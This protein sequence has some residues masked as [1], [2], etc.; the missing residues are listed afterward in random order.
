MDFFSEQDKAR[1]S[2]G[3]LV[4]MFIGAVLLLV[5][6]IYL[7]AVSVYTGYGT[8]SFTLWDPMVLLI[9]GGGSLV[10]IVLGSLYRLA[11]LSAGGI[12]VAESVGGM[13][14]SPDT[15][16]PDERRVLN[17]VEEMA[18]AS[19]MAVPPVYML[20]EEGINAFA[21]GYRQED[22]VIGVTRGAVHGL[23]RDE[24]Q[25]VIAHE[26]SHIFHGDMRLNIRL[27]GVL[28]GILMISLTGSL[29][30]RALW[31]T[32]G[33]RRDRDNQAILLAIA[34]AGIGMYVLG[35]LGVLFGNLI[36][37]AVSRQREYLA[38]ASAVQYTRNPQGIGDALKRLAGFTS[39]LRHPG[40]REASHM[41]FG[42]VANF[43]GMMATHPPLAERIRRIDPSFNAAEEQAL[44]AADTGSAVAGAA[45][46]AGGSGA[47]SD[48]PARSAPAGVPAEQVVASVGRPGE[49]HLAFGRRVLDEVGDDLRAAS[50][51]P[52]SARAVTYALLLDGE[53]DSVRQQ[54]WD[55]LDARADA[56]VVAVTR[57]LAERVLGLPTHA[58][59]PLLELCL[60]ALTQMAASQRA[61]ALSVIDALITADGKVT[62]FEYT[63]RHLLHIHLDAE[64]QA[65]RRAAG[66]PKGKD[67]KVLLSVL[68][69]VGSDDDAAAGA[70]FVAAAA[71]LGISVRADELLPS[72]Q[73]TWKAMDQALL[74]LVGAGPEAKR[75]YLRGCVAAVAHDGIITPGE[76]DLVRAVAA[77]F[78]LPLP[79]IIADAA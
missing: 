72:Q 8:K 64:F 69:R 79:P 26:F 39:N 10:I 67:L 59:L 73:S 28:Y 68:S 29:L 3:R 70:S 65:R 41:F 74:R 63:L 5:A 2:S 21:A 77:S 40:T 48:A 4:W 43:G 30:M 66:K 13:R 7:I 9:A 75:N 20:D 36:K 6:L 78:D 60:P 51:E 52:Y 27:M 44:A 37:A 49:N 33:R 34:V 46:F 56:Q 25:G 12:A 35:L 32:G 71:E 18:I 11:S 22:A 15:R 50:H 38:D 42:T 58:R 57:R 53:D 24:L 23:T 47:R 31:F 76:G 14:I 19:G 61:T 45:G 54:Q 55:V 1:R 62:A 16:D 17:V